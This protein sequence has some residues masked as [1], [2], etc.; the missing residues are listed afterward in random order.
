[1]NTTTKDY[2]S[3]LPFPYLPELVVQFILW[4]IINVLCVPFFTQV[5]AHKAQVV[6]IKKALSSG[7]TSSTMGSTLVGAG[8]AAP[9]ES[10]KVPHPARTGASLRVDA[11]CLRRGGPLIAYTTR[12]VS[13][14]WVWGHLSRAALLSSSRYSFFLFTVT[15]LSV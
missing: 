7:S 13:D 11:L 14:V 1:M 10:V 4:E 15:T 5:R 3:E 12:V 8:P 6:L 9:A 2:L